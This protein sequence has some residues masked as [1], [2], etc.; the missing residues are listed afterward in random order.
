MMIKASNRIQTF[1]FLLCII[2]L[3]T[4]FT[5]SIKAATTQLNK[6]SQH[7]RILSSN[8]QTLEFE[9]LIPAFKIQN[10]NWGGSEFQIIEI[11]GYN[12]TAESGKPQVPY[13]NIFFGLPPGKTARIEILEQSFENYS[14]YTILPSPVYKKPHGNPDSDIAP[15]E[16]LREPD[17][18]IYFSPQFFPK[19]I[20]K[21][22]ESVIARNQIIQALQIFPIQYNPITKEIRKYTK[23]KIRIQFEGGTPASFLIKNIS[24]KNNPITN[25]LKNLLVNY[26]EAQNWKMQPQVKTPEKY[27]SK[28]S[29]QSAAE[30]KKLKLIIEKDGIYQIFYNELSIFISNLDLIDP[31]KI[32]IF[33]RGEEIAIHIQG[34]ADGKFD[35][36]DFLEFY[37]LGAR[38]FFTNKNIYWLIVDESQDG[39][40]MLLQ[41]SQITGNPAKI[42]H[43]G[44]TTRFEKDAIYASSMPDGAGEDHWFWDFVVAPGDL[45]FPINLPNLQADITNAAQIKIEYF[46]FSS[47]DT[48]PDHHTIFSVNGYTLADNFW[49]GQSRL[50]Q[51]GSIAQ[52][53]LIAG[54]NQVK[55]E[56]PGDTGSSTDIAYINWIE[57]E[58]EQSHLAQ[59]DSLIIECEGEGVFQIEAGNFNN[60]N[61]LLFDITKPAAPGF[62]TNFQ[63]ISESG[64]QKIQFQDTLHGKK[65]YFILGKNRCRT[66]QIIIDE[67]SQLQSSQQQADYIIITH[68]IFYS[69]LA[70]LAEHRES[71]GVTVKIVKATDIY[72]EFNFGIK[73]PQAIRTF[74]QNAFENWQKPAPAYVLLVGDASYDYKNHLKT[75]NEDLLPTHLFESEYYNTETASDN[76]FACV[77][78]EDYFPDMLI[79]RLPVKTSEEA[80]S[81]V[82]KIIAYETTVPSSDWYK[83]VLVFADKDDYYNDFVVLSDSL[84]RNV[85]EG[86]NLKKVYLEDYSDAVQAQQAVIDFWNE[87][88]LIANYLG[89]GSIEFL[90]KEKLLQNSDIVKLTNNEKQ[91]FA[92]MLSCLSGFFHHAVIGNCLAE[93]LVKSQGNGAIGCF[94]PS[95]FAIPGVLLAMADELYKTIFLD[96]DPVLGSIVIRAKFGILGAGTSNIDHL[97]FYNLIGDP[98]LQ[99]KISPENSQQPAV[100]S[101]L[102]KIYGNPAPFGTEIL[103]Q[104]NETFYP[105]KFKI[106]TPGEFGPMSINAD[107]VNTPGK[108]GG[109]AGDTVALK[110]ITLENDTLPAFPYVIWQPGNHQYIVLEAPEATGVRDPLKVQILVDDKIVGENFWDGD[111]VMPGSTVRFKISNLTSSLLPEQVQIVL[112]AE[113]QNHTRFTITSAEAD[114]VYR[115]IVTYPIP[116]LETAKYK[117]KFGLKSK[118]QLETLIY[119]EI[120]FQ[121]YASLALDQVMNFPNPFQTETSFCFLLANPDAAEVT[122]KIYTAAGRLIRE[123]SS[124]TASAG[125]NSIKWDGKDDENEYIANGVYFY[126]ISAQCQGKQAEKIGKFMVMR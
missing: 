29:V 70:P 54:E 19:Q 69:A 57:V 120:N 113:R 45:V 89:H 119:K 116:K 48:Q 17:E 64:Y 94:A 93:S 79:G 78:G 98:A 20:V 28:N 59:N 84:M 91:P 55:V 126:K 42:T 112:N 36:E 26:S 43:S 8:P 11:P 63:I 107:D 110:I 41:N 58:Y 15:P 123:I 118:S 10:K 83:N 65:R 1:C 90:A 31:R 124:F 87:G 80:K 76:W 23:I 106:R 38:S 12:Q 117:L 61:L 27:L 74:L 53:S 92:I 67:H 49:D 7:F 44:I 73:N 97:E 86:Y 33:N 22:S 37:G 100:L 71:R 18:R 109:A 115:W 32:R 95:G 105:V 122:I 14:G 2:L 30:Q 5:L 121:Y 13:K 46:G 104:I 9:I 16:I 62:L 96:E 34:E 72:D 85:S 25:S 24:E 111:P 103:A 125:F 108:E 68:E 82:S 114:P 35:E 88:C 99:I 39:K 60:P 3:S 102:L 56:F 40:R 66:P 50:L 101:G 52:N 75:D 51:T 81:L 4:L 47:T 77:A 6:S 21:L